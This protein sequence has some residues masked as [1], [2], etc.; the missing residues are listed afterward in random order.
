[1]QR[2]TRILCLFIVSAALAFAAF[3]RVTSVEPDMAKPGDEAT[4]M[5]SSLGE[6][7]KLFLTAA[8]KDTEVEIKAQTAEEI[9]FVLPADLPH[10]SYKLTIQ[11]GGVNAAI[12]EQPTRIEVADAAEIERRKK[13]LEEPPPPA[14]EPAPTPAPPTGKPQ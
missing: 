1:M 8:G 6:V 2:R 5:G 9:R 14:E 13:E 11:T 10:G 7:V 12:L 3:P 4:A